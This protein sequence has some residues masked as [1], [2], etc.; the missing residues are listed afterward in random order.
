MLFRNITANTFKLISRI[1]LLKVILHTK[2]ITQNAYTAMGKMLNIGGINYFDEY[3]IEQL[4]FYSKYSGVMFQFIVAGVSIHL[5]QSLLKMPIIVNC[6]LYCIGILERHLL[7]WRQRLFPGTPCLFL[8]DNPRPHSARVKTVWLRRHRVHVLY[9]PA[10][11]PDLSPIENVW[12]I[13]KRRIR[14]RQP[15]TVE[16]LKSCIHQ[17]WA[18]FPHLQNCNNWYHQFLNDYKVKWKEMVMPLSQLFLSVL[19]VSISKF[20]YI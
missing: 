17:E 5:C 11:S 8:Q 2:S 19:Q 7:L 9:W 10:F 13:L 4:I 18:T 14:Q 16:Q 3:K 1:A 20:V 15:W 12:R 6:Q